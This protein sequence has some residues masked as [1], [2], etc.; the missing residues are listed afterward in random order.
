M[1][2]VGEIHIAGGSWRNGFYMDAHDG[3][4]PEAVWDLLEESLSCARMCP[5]IVFEIL[6]EYL[7]RLSQTQSLRSWNEHAMYGSAITQTPRPGHE[8]LVSGIPIGSWPGLAG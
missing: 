4:V 2:H 7:E 5:A 3:R 8:P 1:D 6:D